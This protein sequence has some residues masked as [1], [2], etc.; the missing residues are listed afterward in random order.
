M[1]EPKN[2]SAK[3][4]KLTIM[5]VRLWQF[6]LT[7]M[8]TTTRALSSSNANNRAWVIPKDVSFGSLDRL[9][10]QT[11][12][13]PAKSNHTI[14]IA[15]RA[16]GLNFADIFTV[17]GYYKAANEVRQQK[18]GEEFCPGLEF[19]G[20]VL[21]DVPGRFKKH[22]R[23]FGVT[24]FG[25]YQDI[26]TTSPDYVRTLPS[27]WSFEQGASFLVNALTAWHG[28]VTVAGMPD[29]SDSSNSVVV[30]VHSA[31]GG[32][33]LWAS[34]IAARRGAIVIGVVGQEE[35]KDVFYNR[36]RHLCPKAQCVVRSSSGS[37]FETDLRE[38]ALR[39]R[40]SD[41]ATASLKNSEDVVNEGLGIDYIMECYGGKYFE[42]SLNLLNAGGSLATYGSTT[43]NGDASGFSIPLGQ[44]IWK[45]LTRP[46][47][48]P[49]LLTTRNLRVGGF[50]L[51]FLTER[52]D[53]LNAALD[54][55]LDCLG[56]EMTPAVVGKTF[57]YDTDAVEALQALRSGTTVGKVVLSNANNP[58]VPNNVE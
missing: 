12:P 57:E 22:D 37:Q 11:V 5:N 33:G 24:R 53:E 32:V 51:I 2:L 23:V 14:Q 18:A 41:T 36:I 43:Y 40:S 15:T 10:L 13:T 1:V 9:K 54:A 19:S 48:D 3:I 35:K 20:V 27:H 28:L 49:G 8:L 16:I 30:L 56:D 21:E 42:P 26:V 17:C 34:E 4:A 6:F 25:A 31:A 44:L 39:A 46:K 45:Y 50:N 58:N 38:A 47:L 52:I 55:C 7:I 29:C